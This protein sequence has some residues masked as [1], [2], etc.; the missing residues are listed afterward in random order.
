MGVLSVSAFLTDAVTL[1]HGPDGCTHINASLLHTTLAEHDVFRIPEIVST[2][3]GE[4]E[5]IF[6]GEDALHD[7]LNTVC[8]DDP[9]A[10]VV[11]STCVSETI[12]DDVAGICSQSWDC[13]VVYVPSSGFLGG[14]FTDGY[15]STLTALSSFIS[16]GEQ[17]PDKVN[18]VGEKNLEFEAEDNFREVSRILGMLDLDV[19][20]RYVRDI[21]VEDIGRF[22]DAGLNLFREDKDGILG[23][24]F[25]ACTGIPSL[26]EFPVGLSATLQFIGDAGRLTGRDTTDAVRA[27]EER[28]TG[29]AD[30]FSDLAGE[31]VTFDSF[32]FQSAEMEMFAEVA[33]AVGIRVST[34]GTVIPIP[35]CMPVGTLGLRRMLRQWRRFIDG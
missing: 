17:D 32:G 8:A 23:R 16:P 6:G 22:G 9:A 31:Y 13:P 12:G 30:E 29:L 3:L 15:N 4:N 34:E 7:A 33:E 25:N 1:I 2:G 35:F 27:E 18:I 14:T 26:P 19:N 28:Q 24:H 5:I 10:V 11:A 20:I 21:T